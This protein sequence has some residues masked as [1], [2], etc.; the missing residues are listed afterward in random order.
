MPVPPPAYGGTEGVVDCLARGLHDL[1]HDVLLVTTG[2]ATCPVPRAALLEKAE[3]MRIGSSVP[4][5]RHVLYAYGAVADCDIV[6]DHTMLGPVLAHAR[7]ET[8]RVV[9]T[10]HGE[11][12]DELSDV[13]RAIAH[14]I[15]VLAISHDQASRAGD[16][17]IARVIH[18]GIDVDAIEPGQGEGG[19]YLFLGRMAPTKGAHRAARA[20][21][22]AGVRLLIAAKMRE[23]WEHE[24][25]AREVAPLLGDGVEY[26]GEV[27]VD[28][29]YE[30][31][32]GAIALVNPIRW[33]EPFGLVMVEALACGTPVVTFAE[34]AAP[35]IVTDGMTG[36]VCDDDGELPDAMHAAAALDRTLCRKVAETQFSMDRMAAE[37]ARFYEHVLSSKLEGSVDG[38]STN[39]SNPDGAG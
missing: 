25:F 6:H 1:G 30:L 5:L 13:Y 37:H 14:D 39:P 32:R 31:L 16:I 34:G 12:N 9:T 10:N 15:P 11:F 24:Y 2:D 17:P 22:E 4:E 19:Y 26:L 18:H 7:G 23:A 20:A 8:G 28:E 3:G 38:A 36:F 29:K 27:G 21:R 35:E 33:A